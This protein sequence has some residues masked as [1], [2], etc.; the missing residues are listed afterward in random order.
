MTREELDRL[1][2]AARS[3]G[4]LEWFVLDNPWRD[5]EAE[6]MVLEGSPDPHVATP[7]CDFMDVVTAGVEDSFSEDEWRDR[8]DAIAAFIAAADPSVITA[9]LDHIAR[10]ERERDKLERE[11]LAGLYLRDG[12]RA[13]T[14]KHITAANMRIGL[15]MLCDAY[16]YTATKETDSE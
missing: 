6:T 3:L 14:D 16:D 7:V 11:A 13:L 4:S 9:L 15:N 5:P 2:A 12:L 10:L 8:N 1:R